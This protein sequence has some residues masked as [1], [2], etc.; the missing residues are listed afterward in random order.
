MYKAIFKS[1]IKK[2]RF[3][4]C[5]RK[6]YLETLK[7]ANVFPCHHVVVHLITK[8]VNHR[9]ENVHLMKVSKILCTL[10]IVG[11]QFSDWMSLLLTKYFT[12]CEPINT[13]LCF[14]VN[15]DIKMRKRNENAKTIL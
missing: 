15:D 8:L 5:T 14:Y 2:G 13:G 12:K 3:S 4:G 1:L 9:M 11:N 10:F 6:T 7:K